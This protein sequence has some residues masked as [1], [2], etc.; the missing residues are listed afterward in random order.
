MLESVRQASLAQ[1]DLGHGQALFELSIP[2]HC[3]AA[4]LLPDQ[5]TL[6]ISE[7]RNSFYTQSIPPTVGLENEQYMTSA[8]AISYWSEKHNTMIT[9]LKMTQEE[10]GPYHGDFEL[11]F[12]MPTMLMPSRTIS[13]REAAQSCPIYAYPAHPR[14]YC[15]LDEFT[16]TDTAKMR[17]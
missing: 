6:P 13:S 17:Y 9:G 5:S 11:P 16:S 1:Q 7:G 4:P 14:I 12:A 3:L 2:L 10:A 15:N 8:Y